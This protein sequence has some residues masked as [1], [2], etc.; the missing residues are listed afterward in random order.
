M[1]HSELIIIISLFTFGLLGGFSHCAGMCGP[2]VL[3]QVSNRLN[4]I[5]IEQITVF[6]KLSGLALLPYHCGRITTYC[7]IA[8]ISSYLAKNLK[9]IAGFK[10]LAG[11]LLMIGAL[12]IFN[13]TIAKIKLPFRIRR[14]STIDWKNFLAFF[15][16]LKNFINS[17]FLNPTG[18]KNYF[19]GIA[20]GFIPCGLVYGA[21]VTTLSLD[22]HFA[23]L[24]AMLAFGIGTIPALFMT[25]CGGYWFF[26]R[27]KYLKLFTKIIL[28]INIVT[29]LV[30]AFGLIFN[31]I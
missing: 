19:L 22:N 12:I 30:M 8:L 28:L 13:S 15:S 14:H 3:T 6:K 2:F 11:I 1:S 29:L 31:Q 16:F 17:L 4:K 27:I 5:S 20:L 21:I 25:A 7:F 10:Q 26:S 18:L 9:N 23:V 24:L